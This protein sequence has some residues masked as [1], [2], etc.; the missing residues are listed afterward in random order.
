MAGC[1]ASDASFDDEAFSLRGQDQVAGMWHMLRD[2]TKARGMD[3]WK[4]TCS[5]IEADARAGKSHWEADYCFSATGRMVHNVIDGVFA[6]NEQGLIVRHLDSFYF[7]SWS[8]QA[9]GAPGALLGW[10]PFLRRKVR[11][12]AA[13]NLAAYMAQRKR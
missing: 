2:A 12:Q 13:A 11:A 5:G 7:W 10:T 1:Y 9:L 6:F 8:R 4:L 3:T